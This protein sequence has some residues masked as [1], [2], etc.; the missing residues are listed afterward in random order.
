MSAITTWHRGEVA[1]RQKMGY[2]KI[3]NLSRA[4]DMISGEMPEQH[5]TFYTTRLHF[6][7]ITTLDEEGRPWGS[8]ATGKGGERGFVRHP[9]YNTL[10]FDIESWEGDPLLENL[11]GEGTSLVAGIGVE[12]STRRRNKFAGAILKSKRDGVSVSLDVEV[13]QAIGYVLLSLL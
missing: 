5:S 3:P 12:V 8:I 6:L 13:T 1:V 7:P 9:K 11:R 10:I 4:F 2:D